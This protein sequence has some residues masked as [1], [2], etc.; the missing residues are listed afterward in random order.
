M[1]PLDIQDS[2]AI[3]SI[4]SSL[5]NDGVAV[6]PTDT[7]YGFSAALSSEDAY[8][9][10]AAIKGSEG[11]RHFV[12]LAASVDMVA[13]YV[14]GWGDGFEGSLGAIWPAPLTAVLPSG[15]LVPEWVGATIAF[16]VPDV[17]ELCNIIETLGQPIIST[18]VNRAGE[19]PAVSV[20][21]ID[22]KFADSVDLIVTGEVNTQS[23]PSTIVTFVEQKPRVLR[24][25]AYAWPAAVKP[26]NRRSL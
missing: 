10:I 12:H 8:R 19:R 26:S 3:T 11:A 21:D 16:R 23:K 24:A 7:L 17:P 18:S 25:G 9:R 5:D 20:E 22:H 14:Q 6:L 13:R 2:D 15:S 4:V 1:Q